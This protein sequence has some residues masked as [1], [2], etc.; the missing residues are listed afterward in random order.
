MHHWMHKEEQDAEEQQV[1][2][3]S[4]KIC[5]LTGL[6]ILQICKDLR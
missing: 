2:L 1:L 4:Y 5:S 6:V 3:I